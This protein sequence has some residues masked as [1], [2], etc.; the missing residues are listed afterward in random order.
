MRKLLNFYLDE[1]GNNR[2]EFFTVGGFYVL[3]DNNENIQQIENKTKSNILKIE[4]S[5]K[6]FRQDIEP[7]LEQFIINKE[8]KNH[9]EVKWNRLSSEN[10][11]FL[12]SQIRNVGQKNI[13][14][15]CNLVNWVSS[16]KQK[17]NLDA[18]YNMMVL[19][20]IE[21][22][23]HQLKINSKD[24]VNLKLYID[25]RKVSPKINERSQKLESLEGYLLTSLIINYKFDNLSVRVIQLDSSKSPSIRYAD[26]TAGLINSMCRFLK[27][28]K[29][30]WDKNIDTLYNQF[31]TKI[32]CSCR[33]TIK[34]Q[35][36]YISELCTRCSKIK[37]IK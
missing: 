12:I 22:T 10:K 15:N 37:L 34:N 4:K 16:R 1:S 24:S 33:S 3:S 28:S 32:D 19:Y 26:Y 11:K 29:L 2:S 25:Q 18:I 30:L 35:C 8:K 9:T 17:I 7:D 36:Q 5:I 31:H 27:G 21:R 14:I 23:L 13:N 20:L 6:K